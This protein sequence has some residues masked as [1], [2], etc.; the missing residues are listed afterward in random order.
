MIKTK[1]TTMYNISFKNQKI[2]FQNK[3]MKLKEKGVKIGSKSLKYYVVE[4]PDYVAVAPIFQNK[5]LLITQMRHGADKIIKNIP[6]GILQKGEKLK[7]A[8]QWELEEE[9]GIKIKEADLKHLGSFYIAPSFTPIKGH[10]FMVNCRN[11]SFKNRFPDE[12][13]HEFME[14]KWYSMDS[15]PN[16]NELDL[17]S[18]LA[19]A[20]VRQILTKEGEVFDK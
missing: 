9:T 1:M 12:E 15:L 8:A 7:K 17:T 20:K 18:Q 11:L 5:I 16:T 2:I 19:I 3:W 10:L 4:R 13:G 14:I 6:M